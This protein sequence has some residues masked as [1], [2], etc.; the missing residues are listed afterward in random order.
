MSVQSRTFVAHHYIPLKATRQ[1]VLC[2]YGNG[3]ITCD[4][5]SVTDKG[6][7]RHTARPFIP[8]NLDHDVTTNATFVVEVVHGETASAVAVPIPPPSPTGGSPS[9]RT[10][11]NRLS[12]RGHCFLT[13]HVRAFCTKRQPPQSH[14]AAFLCRTAADTQIKNAPPSVFAARERAECIPSKEGGNRRRKIDRCP[15]AEC[16]YGKQQSAPRRQKVEIKSPHRQ[17]VEGG[18]AALPRRAGTCSVVRPRHR[19]TAKRQ[20]KKWRVA[21]TGRQE[22]KATRGESVEKART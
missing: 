10:R 7:P 9:Y 21:G 19:F 1:P 16:P 18:N 11:H 14:G 5:P 8:G 20:G 17:E 15:L 22:E 6:P 4:H 2:F 13:F 3:I 12:I